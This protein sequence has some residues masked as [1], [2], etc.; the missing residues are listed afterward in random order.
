MNW[1][2]DLVHGTSP[3]GGILSL[4]IVIALGLILGAVKTRG[5]SLGVA[6][7]TAHRAIYARFRRPRRAFIRCFP[8]LLNPSALPD[9]KTTNPTKHTEAR[10]PDPRPPPPP[11]SP[12][13]LHTQLPPSLRPPPCMHAK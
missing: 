10:V 4:A 3:A 5:A 2:T 7:A 6:Y 8:P 11:K 12:S 13:L 9:L 1:L